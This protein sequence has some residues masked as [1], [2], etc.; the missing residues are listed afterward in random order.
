LP[1]TTSLPA[2][3]PPS[4]VENVAVGSRIS[5]TGVTF[6]ASCGLPSVPL[7]TSIWSSVAFGKPLSGAMRTWT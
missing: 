7:T 5:S 2:V 1:V 6:L 4:G 3:P